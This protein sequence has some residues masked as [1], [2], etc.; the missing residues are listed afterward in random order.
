LYQ[1]AI[2]IAICWLYT[3]STQDG[4]PPGAYRVIW[5]VCASITRT[6]TGAS[7]VQP[8]R[9]DNSVTV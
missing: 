8:S 4:T 7:N 6:P 3:R 5:P 9:G 2:V 1:S